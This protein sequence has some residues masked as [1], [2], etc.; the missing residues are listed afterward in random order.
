ML[1][2]EKRSPINQTNHS[3]N[4]DLKRENLMLKSK[5]NDHSD[6]IQKNIK[7]SLD[8]EK[9]L[10]DIRLKNEKR[11]WTVA[12][13]S[14][15]TSLCLI[16]G[17]FY[18]LPLKQKEPYL[19]MADV[20]TGQATVAKLVGNWNN[21]N[22]TANEAVN[23]SNVSHFIIA[24]ESF[25]SQIIYDNDWATVYSMSVPNVSDSYRNLMNKSN[26][27]SP[28]NLYGSS[29]SIRVK[30]LSIV[31]DNSGKADGRNASATVR[32][33]RF[34]L[35]KGTGISSFIDSNVATLTYTYN[36][37]LKM[38]E[39]Y[40]LKNPLGFQVLSY[41]VDPDATVASEQELSA[42]SLVQQTAPVVQE[43]ANSNSTTTPES[44]PTNPQT[45]VN[46]ISQS[47]PIP[48]VGEEK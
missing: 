42:E 33:Q 20:Y 19:V 18:M 21:N 12:G 15:L 16:G 6:N 38:D 1:Q 41:R 46:N 11:A 44:Q 5:K 37:N 22:I 17:L 25:D 10:M 48:V 7:K 4:H 31:L 28:F 2:I 14:T 39:K 36:N 23:K 13:I 32:F 8:F 47:A 43:N 26:P 45:E 24:R 30:I 9:T 34:L 27:N 3:Y 40:R 29:R 35:N